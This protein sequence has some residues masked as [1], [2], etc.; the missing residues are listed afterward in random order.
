MK[1]F[2]SKG[3]IL[4]KYPK[5]L[6]VIEKCVNDFFTDLKVMGVTIKTHKFGTYIE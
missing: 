6:A 2:L 3:M 1:L 5:P 4:S